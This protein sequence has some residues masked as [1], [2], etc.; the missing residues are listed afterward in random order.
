MRLKNDTHIKQFKQIEAWVATQTAYL[1]VKEEVDSIADAQTALSI[2][3]A[4]V[5]DKKRQNDTAVATLRRCGDEIINAKYETEFS[6]Y[7]FGSA[8]SDTAKP[9]DITDRHAAVDAHWKVLEELHAA[10]KSILDDDLVIYFVFCFFGQSYIICHFRL[11]KHFVMICVFKTTFIVVL[12]PLSVAG[13]MRV[14]LN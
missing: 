7:T 11:V 9:Q 6:S 13:P 3:A 8:A 1:N 4:F 5:A 2:L 14:R 10:K 12:A